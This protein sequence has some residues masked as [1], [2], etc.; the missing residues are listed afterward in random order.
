VAF[1]V[2]PATVGL[3]G[4]VWVRAAV[5]PESLFTKEWLGRV[6]QGVGRIET[7]LMRALV[8]AKVARVGAGE[9]A[10]TAFV[11]LLALVQRTDVCLQLR[12]CRCRITAA[13]ACVRPFASVGTL[14]VIFGL[15][16]G[17]CLVAALVAARVGA[18]A[19]MAE[20]MSGQLG[21]L[22]EVF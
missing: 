20:Q 10:K 16:G 13:V 21:P 14:V 5:G 18:V 11:R 3:E 2:L 4:A 7:Y 6:A 22:L 1:E 17:E 12:V 8:L 19:S 9:V 15:V